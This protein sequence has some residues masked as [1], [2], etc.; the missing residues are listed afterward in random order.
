MND[1][2]AIIPAAGR[3]SRM[4]S[5][6]ENMPKAMLPLYNKPVI[7]WILDNL[8][9]NGIK[10]V[11]IIIGY[12]GDKI[13][14][15]VN[16]FYSNKI[17]VSY[18]Q[19]DNLYGLGYALKLSIDNIS[20]LNNKYK[21]LIVLGDTIIKENF[22]HMFKESFVGYKEVDEYKRWCL[23]EIEN[24]NAKRFINKSDIDYGIR[25]ALIGVY[26]FTDFDC[27]KDSINYV[28]DNNIKIKNEY[29]ISSAIEKYMEK[30]EVKCQYFD[31]WFDCGEIKTFNSTRKNISRMFNNVQCTEDN[32]I[33]K[34]SK[35]KNK[36]KQEIEWYLN[37]PNK[38]KIYTPQLI[39]FSKS[40][41]YYELERI[42]F[43]PMN[44]LFLFNLPSMEEWKKFFDILFNTLNKFKQYSCNDISYYIQDKL[45]E[46][47]ILNKTKERVKH[48]KEPFF[49]DIISPKKI[50]INGIKYKNIP[51]MLSEIYSYIKKNI[52][53][54]S[55]Q[56]WQIIHGDLFFGNMFYDVHSNTL[57]MIDPRGNFG[58]DTIYGDIRYDIAKMYHSIYGKYDFIVNQLYVITN[59]NIKE[60]SYS[61][62]MY[63]NE[64]HNEI[65]KMF[66][67][68]IIDNG[69][70]L[71]HIKFLTGLL[72]LTAIPFHDDENQK[73]MLY[74]TAVKI[75]NE[76]FNE[77]K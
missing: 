41:G 63:D 11:N 18:T 4:L 35:N 34:R 62:L 2:M 70:N 23:V 32:T 58:I 7:G 48:L 3:G 57:K 45:L 44:E 51:N 40:D 25:T 14:K 33:I 53:P 29:Q 36:I 38:I 77:R 21:L 42:M 20:K 1:I 69:Y 47:I 31:Q 55:K 49:K 65:E 71:E 15:Y 64:Q 73:L 52:L 67:E 76:V 56:Y 6:T 12:Q 37:I 60:N 68:Y 17:N 74:F 5:L 16:E 10:N 43:T 50:V 39:D 61:Y 59:K 72:F 27:F 54:N 8:I 30:Y 46:D 28:I 24:D 13:V 19:Q 75:F 9:D 26:Y 66:N 22:S